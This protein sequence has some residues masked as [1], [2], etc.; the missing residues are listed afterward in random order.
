MRPLRIALISEHASPLSVLGGVDS[1]GQNVYVAQVAKHLVR[2]GYEVD[3]FTRRDSDALPTVMEWG[4][5]RVI[6]VPAGPAKFVRKE[7]LLPY[8]DDFTSF[9]L[10]FS[11]WQKQPYDLIHANF[12]MSGLV[13]AEVKQVLGIPFI[14]T[15]H[16]LGRVRRIY[17]GEADQFSDRRFEVE[18]RV[19]AEAD[20]IIAECPNDRDDLINFYNASPSKMRIIPCG[21][22]PDEFWPMDQVTARASI[23]VESNSFIFLQLGRIVPRKGIDTVIQGFS[24]LL[25]SA[26]VGAKLLVVGGE[27]ADPE[28]D[29]SVEME[30]LRAI[31]KSEGILDQ[32][33]FVGHRG[34]DDLRAYYSAADAFITVPW[35]EPFGITPVESMACGTPVIG[36]N[37]GGIKYS[38]VDGETG[39]LVPP[40]DPVAL[41]KRLIQ[42][43]QNPANLKVMGRQALERAHD[44]FTWQKITRNLANLFESV[45]RE[46]QPLSVKLGIRKGN[47]TMPRVQLG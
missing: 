42:A 35:Y 26:H 30:R 40:R 36:S 5:F 21:F 11:R 39:F 32:V 25:R 38:V 37:V 46:K 17:Q 24:Y 15:F 19:V 43:C 14:V 13:A 3:V 18:D 45:V 28:L 34:R 29:H 1:G 6:H 9:I 44:L 8:M 41:G 2:L 16:A 7:D 23:G 20:H 27:T 31:A 33:K 47:D 12:W 4:G 22:D 10:Q